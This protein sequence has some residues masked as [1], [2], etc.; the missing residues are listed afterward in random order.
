VITASSSKHTGDLRR[1]WRALVRVVS[2]YRWHILGAAGL[3][4]FVL[5]WIGLHDYWT[6]YADDPKGP[7]ASD[8]AYQSFKLFLLNAPDDP[9]MP[10]TLDIARFLAP[11]VFGWAGLSALGMVFRDRL[12]QMRIPSMR[13]HVVICGLGYVG[14]VF[15]RNLRDA[16]ERVVVIEADSAHPNIQLCR[17]LNV[18]VITGDAQLPR[19]LDAAGVRRAA[20][21]LAL[22]PHDSVNAEIVTNARLVAQDRKTKPLYCL[23]MI[24]DP[25]LCQVIRIEESR[26]TEGSVKI[27]F[28]NIDDV[29]ARLILDDA[30]LDIAA[31]SPHI[32]IAHLD[33]LGCALVW[34]AAR[35]WHDN[36]PD[37]TT[38][39]LQITVV[40]DDESRLEEL[41]AR[42][43]DLDRVCEFTGVNSTDGIHRLRDRLATKPPLN[44]AYITAYRD[45]QALE[46]ALKLRHELPDGV[47][48]VVALSRAHGVA[49][50]V[51]DVQS[52]ALVSRL[53]VFQTLERGCTVELV[54]GGSFETMAQ[55]VHR[56]YCDI[57]RRMGKEPKSWDELTETLKESNRAAARDMPVKL[58]K[59]GCEIG[60]LRSWDPPPFAFSDDE[61]ELLAVHEHARFMAERKDAPPE[62]SAARYA[63]SYSEL[64]EENKELD[65]DAVRSIPAILASVGLQVNRVRSN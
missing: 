25:D 38:T 20:R 32:L 62:E 6:N 46:T 57:Q 11:A 59:I 50:L 31:G 55:A 8:L 34:H 10:V 63:E 60:P 64:S 56:H 39:R 41:K 29:S 28:F 40:D 54:R 4:A 19:T 58:A 61:L 26:S 16:Q 21:L 18:P 45:E 65:R 42:Y 33:P 43:P 13:G 35:D 17:Q 36:R 9:D 48:I 5:G 2:G 3:V 14:S 30:P 52:V 15:L 1:R 12:Q 23:A 53:T 47:R 22:T 51:N 49:R 37:G 24:S 7:G 44:C 27:D